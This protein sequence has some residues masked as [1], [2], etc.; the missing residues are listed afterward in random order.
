M[1]DLFDQKI[2]KKKV[3]FDFFPSFECKGS[4]LENGKNW[5][6]TYKEGKTFNFKVPELVKVEEK[7]FLIPN[8]KDKLCFEVVEEKYLV[9]KINFELIE[10]LNYE[11]H[12]YLQ[13]KKNNSI[14]IQ[15]NN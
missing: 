10:N 4:F 15:G 11:Y 2:G 6:F 9:P 13:K 1:I 5:V 3:N 7:K 12:F 14:E 8:L